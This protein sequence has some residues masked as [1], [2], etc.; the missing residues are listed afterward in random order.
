[1]NPWWARP[2]KE[3]TKAG[4]GQQQQHHQQQQPTFVPILP[5]L[6]TRSGSSSSSELAVLPPLQPLWSGSVHSVQD[7]N[8]SFVQLVPFTTSRQ[9]TSSDPQQQHLKQQQQQQQVVVSAGQDQAAYEVSI[10]GTSRAPSGARETASSSAGGTSSSLIAAAYS[11]QQL[12]RNQQASSDGGATTDQQVSTQARDQ[13]QP[14][15][16]QQQQQ[17]QRYFAVGA[18]ASS[19]SDQ[20]LLSAPWGNNTSSST[21]PSSGK[22][23]ARSRGTDEA[24]AWLVCELCDGGTL[25]DLL[26]E[27]GALGPHV[28]GRR[29]MVGDRN[30]LNGIPSITKYLS[31][32][33][34]G[35]CM[36]VPGVYKPCRGCGFYSYP[37][38]LL[39]GLEA[40]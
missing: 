31:I 11:Q 8:G 3:P 19:P 22:A 25:L 12:L 17:Q 32:P 5:G 36:C 7:N 2:G 27:G 15:P 18:S 14:Y 16:P 34:K 4:W 20:G 38:A 33:K 23:I 29:R 39:R 13:L 35:L 9:H 30:V 26:A 24:Q 21:G 40:S 28:T 37:A 6:R 10:C 1:M